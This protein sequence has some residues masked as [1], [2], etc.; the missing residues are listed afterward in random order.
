MMSSEYKLYCQV[1]K[2]VMSLIEIRA[3]DADIDV[4]NYA[5]QIMRCVDAGYLVSVLTELESK[6]LPFPQLRKISILRNWLYRFLHY[7][8]FSYSLTICKKMFFV[9]NIQLVFIIIS[10]FNKIRNTY[11]FNITKI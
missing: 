9:F 11:C 6:I 8:F 5:C 2:I 7:H 4:S 3:L 1:Y 10:Q